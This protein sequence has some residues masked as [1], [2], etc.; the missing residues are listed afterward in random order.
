MREHAAEHDGAGIIDLHA[1]GIVRVAGPGFKNNAAECLV[2]AK[3]FRNGFEVYSTLGMV[4]YAKL[5]L[6]PISMPG[7]AAFTN[8]DSRVKTR[9]NWLT[10]GG[11]YVF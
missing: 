8:V 9:G 10:V 6:A 2:E 1:F 11:V 5:G 4:H 7:N 3:N